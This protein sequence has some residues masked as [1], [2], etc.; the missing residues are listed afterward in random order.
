MQLTSLLAT[1]TSPTDWLEKQVSFQYCSVNSTDAGPIGPKCLES[2][3]VSGYTIFSNCMHAKPS[4]VLL[5]RILLCGMMCEVV[6][7]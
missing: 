1:H 3:Q 6:Q 2:L 5:T 4:V 7:V